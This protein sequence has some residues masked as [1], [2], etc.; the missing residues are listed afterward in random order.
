MTTYCKISLNSLTAKE[1]E[2]GYKLTALRNLFGST[3]VSPHLPFSRSEFFQSSRQHSQ[4]MSISGVQQK[5]SLKENDHRKL[6]PTATGGEYILK[7]S[8]ESFPNAAE[9]EHIAMRLSTLLG[10]E[11]AFCGLVDFAD[12]ELAFITRRFDRLDHGRKL[13]QED[14]LQCFDIPSDNKYDK[15]YEEAGKL[16][17]EVTGGKKAVVLDFLRRVI[18]SYLIGNDDLHLKNFSVQ[19]QHGNT[20]RYYDK[21]T[22]NY[23]CLFCD[24][25]NTNGAEKGSGQLALGLLLDPEDGDEQFSEAQ[26]HYGSYTGID[27]IELGKRLGIPEKPIIKFIDQLHNKQADMLNLIHR[28]YMPEAMKERATALLENRLRALGIISLKRQA[29]KAL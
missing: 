27:F 26:Q 19:R 12:G 18:F 15:T 9:N 14:L 21:L 20:S 22:P 2:V 25:F 3:S 1:V 24:A 6:T 23:D 13:H 28:S 16:V 17:L 10:I 5:L 29:Q 4:G 8:P 7:P 11:T